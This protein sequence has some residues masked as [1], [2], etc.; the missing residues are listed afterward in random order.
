MTVKPRPSSTSAAPA[1]TGE[2]IYTCYVIDARRRLEGVVTVKDLLLAPD[3]MLVRDLM[4][5][6]VI[7]R[8]TPWR[9]RK[10][11]RARLMNKYDFLSLPVVD[12]ENR[13]VG[14]ITVDDAMDVMEQ[15]ATEDFEVMGAY[16]PF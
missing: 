14:I 15:E 7:L 4:S 13:L 12:N 2:A 9:I 11:W 8:L 16:A 1:T 6:D 5:G 3:G 10:R